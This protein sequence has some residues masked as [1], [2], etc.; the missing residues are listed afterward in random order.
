MGGTQLDR[1][2]RGKSGRN[3]VGLGEGGGQWEW[4]EPNRTGGTKWE[5]ERGNSRR[6]LVG[7]GRTQW[8]L[9]ESSRT[10]KGSGS[11]R[12]LVGLGPN[13]TVRDPVGRKHYDPAHLFYSIF[14]LIVFSS[15]LLPSHSS[16]P[17]FF[18]SLIYYIQFFFL[19]SFSSFFSDSLLPSLSHFLFFFPLFLC[20]IFILLRGLKITSEVPIPVA[21]AASSYGKP[22]LMV[23]SM[24][25]IATV[26]IIK[27]K[28]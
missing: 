1:E 15:S 22:I 23:V 5:R 7:P 2:G 19:L 18:F 21:I 6:N 8:D 10:W 26:M 13:G 12:N 25:I 9:E 11:G 16:L 17:L 27:E 20:V 3:P 4:K 24:M 14:F 28:Q